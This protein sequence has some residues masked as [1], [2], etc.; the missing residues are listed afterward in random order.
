MDSPNNYFVTFLKDGKV[1]EQHY[2]QTIDQ[3][4]TLRAVA[5]SQN[6][7]LNYVKLTHETNKRKDDVVLQKKD[8]TPEESPQTRDGWC[9]QILCVE[10]GMI[11][12]S[13]KE[14]AKQF[15][16]S[17]KS[18]WN[19]ANSGRERHG[20]HFRFTGDYSKQQSRHRPA[21]TKMEEMQNF[22][23]A[24]IALGRI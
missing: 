12:R 18:V 21:Q 2:C 15:Q 7:T 5:R 13:V 24:F 14:C 4:N 9:R 17:Y 10:T 20:F 22:G 6:C 16:I 19:A 23:L 1:K 8:H 11:F 3:V